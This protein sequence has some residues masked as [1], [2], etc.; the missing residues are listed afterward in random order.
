LKPPWASA[1]PSGSPTIP[2]P[3]ITTSACF[4]IPPPFRLKNRQISV[5]AYYLC[6][7]ICLFLSH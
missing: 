2:P 3:E 1:R 4:K 5:F 6:K 7:T